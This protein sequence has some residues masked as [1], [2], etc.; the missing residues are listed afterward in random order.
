MRAL[1]TSVIS[2]N[3][4]LGKRVGNLWISL[5]LIIPDIRKKIREDY[6]ITSLF[7]HIH[8][9]FDFICK[10]TIVYNLMS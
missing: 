10:C 1:M 6:Y 2:G 5:I 3:R 4:S 9:D 7:I 8:N